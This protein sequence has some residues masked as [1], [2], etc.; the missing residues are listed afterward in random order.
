MSELILCHRVI[1]GSNHVRAACVSALRSCWSVFTCKRS[2]WV[3]IWKQE[4]L[5]GSTRLA[6][7]LLFVCSLVNLSRLGATTG[8]RSVAH[9][10]GSRVS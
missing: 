2:M 7:A 3:V 5:E 10:G 4:G 6:E 1:Q 8:A 9:T